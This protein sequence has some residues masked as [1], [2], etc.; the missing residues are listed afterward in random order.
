MPRLLTETAIPKPPF[1]LG[2]ENRTLVLGSCFA[3]SVGS[4]MAAG[5][6]DVLVNP[7][8]TLYNPVSIA[9]AVDRLDSG[10]PFGKEDCVEMGAGAGLVCS[11]SHH[12]RF[13]RPDADSFLENANR[14]LEAACRFWETCD[15]VV[16]TFGT[17]RTW[18]RTQDGSTVAN[19]LKR[20]TAEFRRETLSTEEVRDIVL[21]LAKDH[22]DRKFL[23]TVSPIRH[24]SDGAHENNLSKAI[25]LLGLEEALGELP[26][27]AYF[28]A[29]EIVLDELRDYRFYAEDL[30]H[31][32]PVA[33]EIIWE[34]FLETFVP[35]GEVPAVREKEKA[36]RRAA[37]IPF[38]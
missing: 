20:P 11:F 5:G 3:D 33:V 30:C 34:K 22:P 14:E 1:T 37:H 25:L 8:G 12:T 28:P 19:C 16:I 31:P 6:F 7:F 4:K 15:R 17:A 10:K 24:L 9:N 2:P 13:A 27:A 23:F 36:A 35:A 32:S 38:R 29:Y 21:K 26:Q 18:V